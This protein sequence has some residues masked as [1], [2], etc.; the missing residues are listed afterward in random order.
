MKAE[1]EGALQGTVDGE[2]LRPS[3]WPTGILND[4]GSQMPQSRNIYVARVG[5]LSWIDHYES[6]AT[7]ITLHNSVLASLTASQGSV[8]AARRRLRD[9]REAL[10]AKRADLVQMWGRAQGV[11]ESLR[12]LD[13]V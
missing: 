7:A 11:K 13:V 12:L 1:I 4:P 5:Y 6:F 9:S 2:L 8:S 10:G 3:L